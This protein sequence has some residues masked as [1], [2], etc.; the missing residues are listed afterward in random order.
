M[1]TIST[2]WIC[3]WLWV[4]TYTIQYGFKQLTEAVLQVCK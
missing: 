2:F 1:K 3:F 4:M